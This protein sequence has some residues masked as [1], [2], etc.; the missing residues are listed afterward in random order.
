M[1][2][3]GLTSFVTIECR[4]TVDSTVQY[5]QGTR[6]PKKMPFYHNY[7]HIQAFLQERNNFIACIS[8][9]IILFLLRSFWKL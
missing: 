1:D 3:H 5:C 8:L 7:Q 9:I 6:Y 4:G 2:I